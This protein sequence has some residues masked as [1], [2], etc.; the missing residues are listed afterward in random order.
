LS[1]KHIVF[2]VMIFVLILSPLEGWSDFYKYVDSKG[3]TYFVDD[4]SKIPVEYRNSLETLK[5]K[6][7]DPLSKEQRQMLLEK[8][9]TKREEMIKEYSAKEL[10][11]P[12]I[13]FNNRVLV[14]VRIGYGGKEVQSILLLDT[15][16]SITL[17]NQEIA[18]QLGV[19]HFQK[20]RG[21]MANGKMINAGMA[22]LDYIMVGPI[23]KE[24]VE[25]AIVEHEGPA[26]THQG[27]LGM[28][29]LRGLEYSI[30]FPKA[31][32]RWKKP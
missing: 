5:E 18:N 24:N 25:V 27:L 20:A 13:I 2:I 23:K 11:T 28:N 6:N 4:I 30:D 9:K 12:V 19:S 3:V 10:E 16:A 31:I 15:G 17:L 29:F 14:P 1:K 32:I 8:E 7:Y 22:T 21:Q 26:E